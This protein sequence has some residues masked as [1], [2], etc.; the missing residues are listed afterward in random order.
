MAGTSF[1]ISL[2][3][4]GRLGVGQK[5]L[6]MASI[7]L[8]VAVLVG[9]ILWAKEPSYAVLFTIPD[10]KDG[11]HEGLRHDRRHGRTDSAPGAACPDGLS[12]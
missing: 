10:E 6:T 12:P 3:A 11:G 8:I 7:A 5:M 9:G 4:F 1:P 2:E